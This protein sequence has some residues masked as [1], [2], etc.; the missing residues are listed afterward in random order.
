MCVSEGRAQTT[1]IENACTR[2]SAHLLGLLGRL[3]QLRRLGSRQHRLQVEVQSLV[4]VE[5]T[6]RFPSSVFVAH[7]MH[8]ERATLGSAV[9]GD[10]R[11]IVLLAPLNFCVSVITPRALVSII[12]NVT[13]GRRRGRQVARGGRGNGEPPPTL[14]PK[15]T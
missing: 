4:T 14:H 15:L 3:G 7:P 5:A 1:Q 8:Q 11:D 12:W 13:C 6:L 9:R 2:C 10:A